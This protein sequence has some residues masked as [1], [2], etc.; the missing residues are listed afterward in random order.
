M[1]ASRPLRRARNA[2]YWLSWFHRWSGVAFCLFFA[3][4]FASGLVM[5]FVPFPSLV[6]RDR[7]AGAEP[8]ELSR[9]AIDPASALAAAGGG[10]TLRLVSIT[11]RPYYVAKRNA[12]FSVIDGE[13]GATGKPISAVKA[14]AIAAGFGAAR[15]LSVTGPFDY[16]QW[17]VH[18]KF[19][20]WRPFYRL[21]LEDAEGTVLYV[22]ARTGEVIQRTRATERRWNWLGSVPHWLYFT[23]LRQSFR[24]WDRTVWWLALA[25]L[26]S[27]T[28]GTFL[29]IYRTYQRVALKRPGWS[30]FRGWLRWHHGLGL[31][32]A[33]FVLMWIFSGWLSM[34]HGRL[35]S[36]GV[37]D[38]RSTSI[39]AGQPLQ[40]ALRGIPLTALSDLTGS[41]EIAFHVVG[42]RPVVVGRN[43]STSRVKVL[44]EPVSGDVADT[45]A[46]EL[47]ANAAARAWPLAADRQPP[48]PGDALYREADAIPANA[49]RF[50]LAHPKGAA[51]YI[52]AET[53][54]PLV[55]L[56]SSRKAY[57]WVYLALHTTKFPGL[58]E[59][60][61]LRR[62]LQ[63]VLLLLGLAFT[64]T[65][66]IL[67]TKRLIASM[68]RTKFLCMG[69]TTQRS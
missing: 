25:A 40:S 34:D 14:E 37:P 17:V 56:D 11:G 43:A 36:R 68:P 55:L 41:T 16:D 8:L 39:Y 69:T 21:A 44:D 32:A 27:A 51:L 15:V 52:D 2:L 61:M 20:P 7:L 35:F 3:V 64:L 38:A 24:A 45:L 60:P 12:S 23:A 53:G 62:C 47:I 19:D 4:W 65:G 29:G 66:V 63:I 31:A 50:E 5:V 58:V 22:S 10:E 57:A 59:R 13:T 18:N 67:G 9:L 54:R 1:P 46:P 33:V 48:S 30:P 49:L 26:A 42:G 28:V 6:D